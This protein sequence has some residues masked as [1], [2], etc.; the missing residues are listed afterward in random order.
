MSLWPL[1]WVIS[2]FWPCSFFLGFMKHCLSSPILAVPDWTFIWIYPSISVFLMVNLSTLFSYLNPL[3]LLRLV[4]M[5]SIL[6]FRLFFLTSFC[7]TAI[8]SMNPCKHPIL[9][10]LRTRSNPSETSF[11]DVLSFRIY[12]GYFFLHIKP[13]L[14]IS[15]LLC[16]LSFR[17]IVCSSHTLCLYHTYLHSCLSP[18]LKYELLKTKTMCNSFLKAEKL[19]QCLALC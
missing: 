11:C 15:A 16:P 14:I 4:F 8:T 5:Q 2:L 19:K 3:Y 9:Q 18:S 10:P 12:L 1:K 17:V 6:F 7:T 13:P